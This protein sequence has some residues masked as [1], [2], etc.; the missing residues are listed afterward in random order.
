MF[1]EQTQLSTNKCTPRLM[2]YGLIHYVLQTPK[3]NPPQRFSLTISKESSETAHVLVPFIMPLIADLQALAC[4]NE[5]HDNDYLLMSMKDAR[6]DYYSP[7]TPSSEECMHP[8]TVG[9]KKRWSF[10]LLIIINDNGNII[11]MLR[12]APTTC[13][14]PFATEWANSTC[15][16][17][18]VA[19]LEAHKI[20]FL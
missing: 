11:V 13:I 16:N 20:D 6:S 14:R 5:Y 19:L 9:S 10:P 3:N 15:A 4:P 17:F 2:H 1:N 12:D 7:G 8:T 18:S